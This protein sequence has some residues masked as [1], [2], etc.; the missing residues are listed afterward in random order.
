[1]LIK[2]QTN[3]LV[4]LSDFRTFNNIARISLIIY[5][6]L[7][8]YQVIDVGTKKNHLMIAVRS[9]K[10]ASIDPAIALTKA[11]SL[12]ALHNGS[13]V[14]VR[15]D[16]ILK[17]FCDKPALY[18]ARLATL[19]FGEE[20]LSHSCMPDENNSNYTPLDEETLDS[21]ISQ[22]SYEEKPFPNLFLFYSS[23][24]SSCHSSFQATK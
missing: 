17:I 9:D 23:P 12:M 24:C 16:E 1:M 20:T 13:R 3:N 11:Q 10:P 18:S 8:E 2:L 5:D 22:Y 15:K 6:F 14:Y 4:K 7:A 21:I 19:V